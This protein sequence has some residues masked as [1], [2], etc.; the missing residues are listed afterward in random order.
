MPPVPSTL[1]EIL[2]CLVL[3][4]VLMVE[5][6]LSGRVAG[7][8]GRLAGM[9][10]GHRARLERELVKAER[11]A[12]LLADPAFWADPR[13]AG[14][15]MEVARVAADAGRLAL[16]RRVI[17]PRRVRR[18]HGFGLVGVV[19][20][21]GGRCM[22]WVGGMAALLSR[23]WL[24]P[25]PN[26]LPPMGGEGFSGFGGCR[27]ASEGGFRRGFGVYGGAGAFFV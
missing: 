15:A 21:W 16:V 25:S 12:A 14:K 13:A 9:R 17:W 5:S 11:Y 6:A 18:M 1:Q 4:L 24:P 10:V 19:C 3:R 8:W 7:L 23:A 2:R 27:A 22:G 20:D 26:P